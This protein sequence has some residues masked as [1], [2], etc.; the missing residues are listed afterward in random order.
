MEAS[1]GFMYAGYKQFQISIL[2][3]NTKELEYNLYPL[4]AGSVALPKLVLTVPEDS[5][6]GPALR[7]EQIN[8][9]IERSLPT[10]FF[11]MVYR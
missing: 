4:I 8:D 1:D 9:L 7:Q 3:D 6:E 11:V 2:P 5:T 10:H